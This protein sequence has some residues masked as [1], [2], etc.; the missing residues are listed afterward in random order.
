MK[1][2]WFLH[3]HFSRKNETGIQTEGRGNATYILESECFMP[4]IVIRS[5]KERVSREI[6]A[7]GMSVLEITLHIDMVIEINEKA[8]LDFDH[9]TAYE[10]WM[11]LNFDES[12]P[13]LRT[14]TTLNP[15]NFQ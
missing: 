15:L 10:G 14:L 13:V 11:S 1:K 12:I 6:K 2:Y 4:G 3:F 8:V 9:G 7:R 5:L